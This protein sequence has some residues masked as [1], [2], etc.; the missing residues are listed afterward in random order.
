MVKHFKAVECP[1]ER[2]T[3]T[4]FSHLVDRLATSAFG[5]R[6]IGGDFN[7]FL[8]DLPAVQTLLQHGWEEAQCLA[9]RKFGQEIQPTIQQKH[10]KDLLL[11]SPELARSAGHRGPC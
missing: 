4:S 3:I 9:K 6:F 8:D 7:H 1:L 10:T 5:P 11:L 2:P